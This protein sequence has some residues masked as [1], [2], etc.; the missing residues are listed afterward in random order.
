MLDADQGEH[1]KGKARDDLLLETGKEIIQPIRL[2]P[3]F[4]DHALIACQNVHLSFLQQAFS[5]KLPEH[6]RLRDHRSVS[7]LDRPIAATCACPA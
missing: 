4:A 2:F 7:P 5:E 1:E 6:L 3:G